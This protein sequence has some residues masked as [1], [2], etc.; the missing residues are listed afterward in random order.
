[1]TRRRPAFRSDIG[2]IDF[3]PERVRHSGDRVHQWSWAGLAEK[4]SF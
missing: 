3:I 4:W 2:T 1:M